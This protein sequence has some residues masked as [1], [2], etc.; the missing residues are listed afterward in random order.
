MVVYVSLGSAEGARMDSYLNTKTTYG[1]K[2]YPQTR[3]KPYD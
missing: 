1:V 2:K 3:L